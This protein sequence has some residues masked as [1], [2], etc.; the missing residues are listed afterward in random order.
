MRLLTLAAARFVF[1][2][3]ALV[4]FTT[5]AQSLPTKDEAAI[6]LEKAAQAAN[7]RANDA[8]S[9]HLVAQVHYEI[10][11]QTSDG[12][13]ELSWASPD[14]YREDFRMQGAAEIEIAAEDKLYILRNTPALSLPFWSVRNALR[15][16][17]NFFPGPKSK[18]RRVYPAQVSGELLTC[19]D[20]GD[21]RSQRQ[22][23]INPTTNQA[24][25]LSFAAIPPQ[26]PLS[27][28][29]K[30]LKHLHDLEVSDFVDV[31]TKRYPTRI[32]RQEQDEKLEI[33][34]ETL[35]QVMTF[36]EG[37]FTPQAGAVAYDWCSSPV[38]KG[39]IQIDFQP[40]L[41]LDPPGAV[42]AY[43]VVVG[44]DGRVKKWASSRSGGKYVDERM[45]TR[46]R[47]AR[48]PIFSCGSKPI[49]YE[50]MFNAPILMRLPH[51]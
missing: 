50:T 51:Y 18:I 19:V 41:E 32:H 13:Y 49:E 40:I 3:L 1:S 10:G 25:S 28:T 23:C 42:V 46:F 44:T 43:Y 34:I 9:F 4:P 27:M 35:K 6:L 7:L 33:K 20:F 36:A 14:R 11:S 47:D 37:E 12:V 8:S 2:L 48:F 31:G 16:A 39:T 21:E 45:A 17:K 30:E 22:A 15:S 5:Q 24:V 38:A 29:T 26:G